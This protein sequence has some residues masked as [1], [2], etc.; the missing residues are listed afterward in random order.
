AFYIP[1]GSMIPTLIEDDHILVNKLEYRIEPKHHGDVIVFAAPPQALKLNFEEPS[2]DGDPTD[3][4]KRLIG[5]PGDTIQVVRG[6]VQIGN[7]TY[8]HG[9]V[10]EKFGVSDE[11]HGHVRFVDRAVRVFDDKTQT[12]TSYSE[13]DVAQKMVGYASAVQI[14]P[15]YTLRNGVKLDEP[16][17]AED[18]DYDLK[19][20]DGQ[21]VLDDPSSADP[22]RVDGE[23]VSPQEEQKMQNAPPGPIP[24]GYVFAMGDN[25]NQ[26]SDSTRWG[27]LQE[28]RIVGRAFFIFY[29]FGRIR[30]VR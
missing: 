19:I 1:S 24:P 2:S 21:S 22:I 14:H 15:G 4:I 30:V 6:Y 8:T 16:Y 12:W 10:A 7:R 17:I 5:L 13:Q 18:P 20:V 3:Y 23:S 29:P 28:N 11:N 26:S 9:D 27:P 25:R